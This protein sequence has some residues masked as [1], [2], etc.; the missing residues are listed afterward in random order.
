MEKMTIIYVNKS[1]QVVYCNFK[2]SYMNSVNSNLRCYIIKTELLNIFVKYYGLK[3]HP[4]TLNHII[5]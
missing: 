4:E 1:N 5:K 3:L 2:D